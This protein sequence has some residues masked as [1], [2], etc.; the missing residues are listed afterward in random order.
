VLKSLAE[1][2]PVASDCGSDADGALEGSHVEGTSS[3]RVGEETRLSGETTGRGRLSSRS[4]S[5]G[6]RAIAAAASIC[7][8]LQS[9][10]RARRVGV[11]DG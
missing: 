9:A 2:D 1:D 8:E 5:V 6:A 7:G 10:Q 4:E 3:N 11:R